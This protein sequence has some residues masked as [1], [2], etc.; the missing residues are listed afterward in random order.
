MQH[1]ISHII[2]PLARKVMT[3]LGGGAHIRLVG[4]CVRNALLGL[5]V[6]DLDMAT[7]HTP[8]QVIDI[9]GVQ[10]I[11]TIPTGLD[12][13]TVT[14]VI[15][16]ESFEITTLRIDSNQDGRHAEVSF[17]NN[18]IE[19]AQRRDFTINTLLADDNGDVCDPLGCGLK[20]LH[21][22][23]VVFVGAARKRIEEDALRI[24]RFFRFH[25]YYGGEDP[26]DTALR[27]CTDLS[28]MVEGL[29]RERITQE[30]LKILTA[31]KAA[32]ILPLMQ[33]CHVLNSLLPVTH[34][35]DFERLTAR[36]QDY[37]AVHVMARLHALR[38]PMKA[39]DALLA[40]TNKDKKA[41]RALQQACDLDLSGEQPVKEA[42]YRHG[43]QIILQAYLN[44]VPKVSA[45]MIDMIKTWDVPTC[46]VSGDD[47]IREGYVQG[48]AL[49]EELRRRENQWIKNGFK[50]T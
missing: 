11:K 40:L 6:S 29:S 5:S 8:Q 34:W 36:Q 18:W 39:R 21:A 12:H 42:I 14:A 49:G 33:K 26:D 43:R 22:R 30:F 20:D 17:T 7:V 2:S 24:L 45:R 19:D 10:G 27:A 25:T 47:L 32:E 23:K 1:N 13:G 46:P 4:G 16:G 9:L 35:D 31:P 38:V 48:K 37:D 44:G 28:D 50:A 41:L 15:D 3:I